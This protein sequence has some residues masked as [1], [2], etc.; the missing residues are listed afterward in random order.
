MFHTLTLRHCLVPILAAALLLTPAADAAGKQVQADANGQAIVGDLAQ[1]QAAQVQVLNYNDS[2]IWLTADVPGLA[3]TQRKTDAGDFV[4]LSWP[5]SSPFGEIGSPE[6]PVIRRLF[7]APA[8]AVVSVDAVIAAE[9]TIDASTLGYELRVAPRQAP[10]EKLPGARENAPFDFNPAAYA[11]NADYLAEPA[12]IEELGIVREQRLFMLEIHPVT[13][14]P[15]AQTITYRS[16]IDVNVSFDGA[17]PTE[18]TVSPSAHVNRLVLN[19]VDSAATN[20]GSGNYLIIVSTTYETNIAAFAAAKTAQGF[21][22]TTHVVAPGTA[23]TTIKSYI[24]SLWGGANSPDYILLVGDTDTIPAW[25]GGGEG[26]PDTD[27]QYGCMDGSTDWYPDIAIGRF[28]VRSSTHVATMVDKTL[29]C[30]NGP[31]ADPDYMTRAVFMAS[32]DN[33]TISEGTHNYVINTH[34]QPN[35]YICDKLYQVT[36]GADTQDVRDSFNDG[37]YYGI[38]SGHGATTYWADGPQFTQTDINNL[39]NSD[40]YA[41]VCSFACITGTFTYTECFMETWVLAPDKGAVCSWGSS[42]NSYWTEDDILEKVLFDAIFDD[43]DAVPTEAGPIYNESKMRFL[44]HFGA[45]STT[46]RYFEMY[47][48]M[49]DPSIELPAVELTGMRVTPSGGIVSEGNPGG[50]FTVESKDYTI[51]NNS[52]VAI[53]YEVTHSEPWVTITNGIG[54]IPS[55]GTANVTVSIN[56]QANNFGNGV[57]TDTISFANTST[58][59]GD[60]VRGVQLTIGVPEPIIMY[61][62]DTDPGWTMTG[63]WGFGQPTGGGGEHGYADPTSGYTGNNVY[64]YNLSGDYTNSMPEYSLTTTAIDCTDLNEVILKFRRWLGVEQPTYDHAYVRV[65]N[66]GLNWTTVW[67]NSAEIAENDWSLQ[68]YDISAVAD[69]QPTVYVR[70]TQGVSDTSWI[71]CGWN[72]D[73]VEIWALAPSQPVNGDF[74]GDGCVDLADLATLLAN[75]GMTNGAG[76]NDGDMDSDGDVDLS[77]LSAFLSHYGEGC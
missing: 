31:L 3:I 33:Y 10:I 25:V 45:D 2:G 44:A 72:I 24:T 41:F 46:R 30:E 18:T 51:E 63:A 29:Y 22:V 36:Y 20:R 14:N 1:Q 38:Y 32:V 64:G 7:V 58:H 16:Q 13:Y 52:E 42:V 26:T 74:D 21:N 53:D 5:E 68:E 77:D 39:T 69:G 6:L 61:D 48:L 57:Y 66:D 40:M 65:S 15:V 19:P 67:E 56:A 8:G 73:D 47:N 35:D 23:N 71:Y 4:D 9:T 55:L 59:D 50:P 75:Y 60:C 62:M 27:I 11:L 54:T 49:G 28:P 37:R 12:T 17:K 34:L 70:W 43:T 76:P